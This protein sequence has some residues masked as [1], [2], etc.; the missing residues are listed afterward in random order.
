MSRISNQNDSTGAPPRQT[1]HIVN[2]NRSNFLRRLDQPRYGLRPIA[3]QSKQ[4]SLQISLGG[5][6]HFFFARER[7][8]CCVPPHRSRSVLRN[9]IYMAKKSVLPKDEVARCFDAAP[10]D[11]SPAHG[12]NPPNPIMPVYTG[13]G[14]SGITAC[15][16]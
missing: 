10:Y 15:R 16:T 9:H 14:A 4:P 12:L 6:G 3:M 13:F 2:G 8:R 7:S 1:G 11:E 5:R